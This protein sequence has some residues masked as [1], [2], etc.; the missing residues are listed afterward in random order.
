[1]H[2]G[3]E[4][5]QGVECFPACEPC[6]KRRSSQE[7]RSDSPSAS[8]RRRTTLRS[9]CLARIPTPQVRVTA[10]VVF[11]AKSC[12]VQLECYG[13]GEYRKKSGI[14]ARTSSSDILTSAFP[15]IFAR[16]AS[17]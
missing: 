5:G 16:T 1:M 15:D 14:C 3:I 10:I 11:P 8:S 17:A 9:G 4:I 13:R 2:E 12:V 7:G 6:P